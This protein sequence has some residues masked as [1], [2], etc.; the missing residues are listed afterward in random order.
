MKIK[1]KK[2]TKRKVLKRKNPDDDYDIV[3]QL[4]DRELDALVGKEVIIFDSHLVV[5]GFLQKSGKYYN[6][7]DKMPDNFA[8]AEFELKDVQK[9]ESVKRWISLK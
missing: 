5:T 6:V 1:S 2:I 4:I 7:F 3:F 8:D 9:I